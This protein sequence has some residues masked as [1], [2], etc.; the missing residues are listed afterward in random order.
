MSTPVTTRL[1]QAGKLIERDFGV[2]RIPELLDAHPEAVLWVDLL[3]P[4][5]AGLLTVQALYDLHPLAVEDAVEDHQRPKLDHYKNHLFMNV[6]AVHV[7]T[8]P[9]GPSLHKIELSSFVTDRAL[10]T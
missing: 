4:D 5:A 10:I 2:D 6:Y 3:D 8:D 9:S 7:S 1:Y